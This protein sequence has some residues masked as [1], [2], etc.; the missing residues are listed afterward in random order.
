MIII[1]K[2][3]MTIIKIIINNDNNNNNDYDETD[4]NKIMN[5]TNMNYEYALLLYPSYYYEY[6]FKNLTL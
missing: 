1:M 5:E 4:D 2:I 3:I 6:L